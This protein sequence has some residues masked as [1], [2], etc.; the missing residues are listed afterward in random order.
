ME[1][2]PGL[3]TS[4]PSSDNLEVA[5]VAGTPAALVAASPMDEASQPVDLLLSVTRDGLRTLGAQIEDQLRR[6]IR[7]GALKARARIPS[8]RDLARQLDVSRRVV[9]DAYAQLAAEGYLEFRQGARPRVSEGAVPRTVASSEPPRPVSA[10]RF[11]FRPR[12]PDVLGYAQ[13]PEPA[14]RTAVAE[15]AEAVQTALAPA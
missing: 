11:D 8:T 7:D 13:I 14:I 15:L 4:P 5:G 12:A 2:T 3:E 9:A 10:A 1:H 6:A